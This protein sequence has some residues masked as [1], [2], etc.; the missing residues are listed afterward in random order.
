MQLGATASVRFGR[1][2]ESVIMKHSLSLLLPSDA[3][4]SSQLGSSESTLSAQLLT[5]QSRQSLLALTNTNTNT[6]SAQSPPQD[7]HDAT[8]P[9]TGESE[10]ERVERVGGWMTSEKLFWA[11]ATA[12]TKRCHATSFEKKLAST[13]ALL[14]RART[15][16]ALMTSSLRPLMS[17]YKSG[18][19]N[20]DEKAGEYYRNDN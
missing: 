14:R 18:D 9:P 2:L 6:S 3:R 12:S 16:E 5:S 1:S 11:A 10:S 7:S 15:T 4:D 8:A 20:K 17:S 13:T 19:P